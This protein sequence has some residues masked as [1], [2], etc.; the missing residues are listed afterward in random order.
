MRPIAPPHPTGTN[1]S[2]W[3]CPATCSGGLPIQ[4][5]TNQLAR[6]LIQHPIPARCEDCGTQPRPPGRKRSFRSGIPTTRFPVGLQSAFHALPICAERKIAAGNSAAGNQLGLAAEQVAPEQRIN[7]T[8]ALVRAMN[9][10]KRASG[11]M[12]TIGGS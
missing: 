6:N 8:V 11:V 7:R 1:F 12:A 3:P 9:A 4:V 2:R 10:T 5:V